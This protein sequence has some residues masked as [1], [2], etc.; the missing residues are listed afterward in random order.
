MNVL[1]GTSAFPDKPIGA[2]TTGKGV[3]ELISALN[4]LEEGMYASWSVTEEKIREIQDSLKFLL[5]RN[6]ILQTENHHLRSKSST[7]KA[8]ANSLGRES[9]LRE[10]NE[11]LK[12]VVEAGKEIPKTYFGEQGQYCVGCGARF[13]CIETDACPVWKFDK[14]CEEVE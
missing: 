9:L 3:E 11:N 6:T 4:S 14:K 1:E 10:E 5:N 7:A 13:S 12:A 8:L 2:N